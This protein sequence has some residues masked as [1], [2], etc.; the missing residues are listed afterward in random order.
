GAPPVTLHHSGLAVLTRLIWRAQIRRAAAGLRTVKGVLLFL[1]FLA[2]L[3]FLVVPQIV[4]AFQRKALDPATV[5][6]I[7]PVA[8][9]AFCALSLLTPARA[10][11]IVF[12]PAEVDFLFA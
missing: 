9:L 8:L 4:V 7:A 12:R 2:L 10:Q 1:V 5:R 3:S 6:A 11:G